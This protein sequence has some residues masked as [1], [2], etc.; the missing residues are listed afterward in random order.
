MNHSQDKPSPQLKLF[1]WLILGVYSTFFAE[2]VSG[3]DPFPFF[4]PWGLGAV[5]PLYTLHT[6]VLSYVVF[7]YGRPRFTT[8]FLAGTIFGLYE[9]Y[10]TKVLWAPP[11]TDDPIAFAGV[12]VSDFIVLVL[13][14]HP[15]F[16]FIIPLLAGETLLTRSRRGWNGLPD[17]VR[18]LFASGRKARVTLALSA[19]AMGLIAASNALSPVHALLSGISTT[20]VTLLLT[21]LWRE[22][23]G[24][25]RYD[26]QALLPGKRAF[27][28]LLFLL[29]T[30]YVA[31]GI[32]LRPEALPGLGAQ[33]AIWLSYAGLIA[34]LA[35]NLRKSRGTSLAA[36]PPPAIP[37]SWKT[38]GGLAAL[39][40]LAATL[41]RL[42]FA[43]ASHIIQLMI[44]LIGGG[45][46]LY[47]LF[48]ATRD[49]LLD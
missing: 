42:T 8:L 26:V 24:G 3:S 6:L 25:Q 45:T 4:H 39:F 37:F 23:S 16:A 15:I 11:W 20:A 47:M 34:L 30:L 2:V 7:T 49:V 1:F 32:S 43:P 41:G 14:W 28:V 44:W 29:V 5:V 9:A 31:L 12:A 40:T 10:I 48:L 13:F 36:H 22:K 21:C 35:L 33:A 27:P 17:P 19:L 46:G 38:L 18:R